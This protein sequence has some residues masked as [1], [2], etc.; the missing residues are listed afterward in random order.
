MLGN[1]IIRL[2]VGSPIIIGVT[3]EKN[4]FS[5]IVSQGVGCFGVLTVVGSGM[6]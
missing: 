5:L 1:I 6:E 4:R 2:I 3:K